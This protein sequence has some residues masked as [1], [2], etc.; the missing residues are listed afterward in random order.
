MP[1][2]KKCPGC[3]IVKLR[4]EFARNRARKDGLQVHCRHCYQEHSRRYYDA[5]RERVL[6][7][8][9]RNYSRNTRRRNEQTRQWYAENRDRHRELSSRWCRENRERRRESARNR[10]AAEPNRGRGYSAA[11]RA[12]ALKATPAWASVDAIKAIYA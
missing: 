9:K 4:E 5:N 11:H 10:Y 12:A 6:G 3:S 7:R 2:T 1:E 8:S